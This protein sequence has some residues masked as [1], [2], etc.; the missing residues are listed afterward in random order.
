MLSLLFAIS[1]ASSTT[2]MS[3]VPDA[4][5]PEA[6]ADL[7]LRSTVYADALHA[8]TVA[9]ERGDTSSSVLTVID[10]S[11]PPASRRL[12]VVDLDDNT[13]LFHELVAHGKNS[14][15]VKMTSWSDVEGSKQTSI[16][17]SLAAET[18][19]GKHGLSLKM[20]GLEKGFNANNRE[21]AIVM[22]GA[23]YV[24]STQAK[25]TGRVGN[26]WGCPAVSEDVSASLIKTV[27]GGSLVVSWY[28][29][30]TW[31]RTS[32]YLPDR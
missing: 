28:P 15:R 4:T 25:T 27:K 9:T 2:P 14:G 29:D 23:S 12:W 31:L 7:G 5:D 18:Y 10:Y 11:L 8:H 30:K 19:Y 17:V 26:S 1:C 3:T 16:G 32:E 21:R 13:L 6:F 22:H 24:S 20:D